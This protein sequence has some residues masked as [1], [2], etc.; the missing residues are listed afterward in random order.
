MNP[1]IVVTGAASGIGRELSR[2][3]AQDGSFLLLVDLSQKAVG[4]LAIELGAAGAHAEALCVDLSDRDAAAQVEKKLFERGLYC[5]VLINS[6]G[7]GVFGAAAE[8]SRA[9][10]VSLL[11]VN[12]R[13]LTELSLRFLPGMLAR[14]RGGILNVGSV[15]GYVPGPYMAVYCATK[16]YVRSFSAAL[17][18]EVVGRGVTVTCLAPGV[19]RT[20]FFKRCFVGQAR[21]FK[22]APSADAINIA[23]AGWRGFKMRKRV[24][25]PG[26][27]Y[28][29]A[30][31]LCPFIPDGI[32]L[33]LISFLQHPRH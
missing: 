15:F 25:I 18:A 4:E 22:I 33:R 7:F 12:A 11:D 13:A 6:A 31:G 24:V 19:V 2:I 5:D 8:S 29:L 30:I 9:E 26:L 27:I 1:A 23:A 14:G 3:A 10:Q 16:A 21:L 20:A 32:I 28:R 17:A